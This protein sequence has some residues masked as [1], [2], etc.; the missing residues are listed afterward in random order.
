MAY[1]TTT[2]ASDVWSLRDV[3]KAEAGDNWPGLQTNITA[4]GGTITDITDGGV[5]YRVHTFTSSGTFDVTSGSQN[6]EYLIVAG[7]AGGSSGGNGGGGAGGLIFQNSTVSVSSNSVTVG[8]G[9]A[10]GTGINNSGE[11]GFDSQF[12]GLIALGGGRGLG[13]SDNGDGG[14]GGG[15]GRYQIGFGIGLQPASSSGGFGNDGGATSP[16]NACG[17]GGGGA[18]Q[19]G[20]DATDQK[21]GDGG[22]GKDYSSVFGTGV[23]ENGF[24]AG[25]GGGGYRSDSF[26][27]SDPGIGGIGGGGDGYDPSGSGSSGTDGTGGGGGTGHYDGSHFNGFDGGS[28]IVIIRYPI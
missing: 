28:G 9:G 2:A 4:T 20:S 23:G 14:S 25:G 7:G 1:P 8:S 21:A 11:A 6:I 22:D 12:L 19:A 15:A 26:P 18:N 24:F 27:N 16:S 13:D 3:Y 10:A 17:A 5:N